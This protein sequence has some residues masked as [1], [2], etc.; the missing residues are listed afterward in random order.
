MKLNLQWVSELIGHDFENWKP[1]DVIRIEAQ[2]GTGKTEFVK[3]Q[4]LDYAINNEKKI[5]YICNR[6]YLKRQMKKDVAEKQNIP[7]DLNIEAIDN[8][9]DIGFITITSYQKIQ[10][11]FLN[12]LK[13]IDY[14][15]VYNEYLKYDYLILDEIHYV[16]SDASFANE[17][18]FFLD[19]LRQSR[20]NCITVLIS[21]TMNDIREPLEEIYPYSE[22]NVYDFTTGS[23]YSYLDVYYFKEFQDIVTTINND[24]SSNKWLVFVS[25]IEKALEMRDE[26]KESKF[27]CSENSK[28]AA[29]MDMDELNNLITNHK[30]DCKCLIATKALDNGINIHD[31]LLT[32]IVIA[33]FDKIDFIQMLGRKRI[34]I[35]NAQKVNLYIKT[36]YKK[37]FLALIN[38]K[39]KPADDVVKLWKYETANFN[40]KYDTKIDELGK[41][42]Y[43]FY[44]DENG[45]QLNKIG[46]LTM[47]KQ[48]M[49]CEYMVK[50]YDDLGENAFIYTQLQWINQE[51]NE[52]H[53]IEEVV[54]NEETENL[55]IYLEDLVGKKL[56]KK[57][58]KELI[59]VI[60][61]KD[62][63]GRIKKTYG[64]F[65]ECFKEDKI[66]FMIIPKRTSKLVDGIKKD[67]R[68]WEVISVINSEDD[69]A[70]LPS[71]CGIN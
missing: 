9:D 41:Y 33:V 39:Y 23:D 17:T 45:W 11:H 42:S 36:R 54:D 3:T 53:W 12:N 38:G 48:K 52:E 67:I 28:Y 21:A 66:P 63:K 62:K 30:F 29:E 51:Y 58:Q 8:V 61:L 68:Y 32:N 6:V 26:I 55:E 31:L 25:N 4:L 64:V 18:V 14:N 59:N 44:R 35:E 46:Y 43:L 15:C 5:L 47:K 7:M 10:H 56:L 37:S 19:F 71:K 16:C 70:E 69:L 60:G 13:G 49:F 50:R 57:E 40:R 1:G 20:K 34:N 22:H 2:T 65:N 24:H 27:I